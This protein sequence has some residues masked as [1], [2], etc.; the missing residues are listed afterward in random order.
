MNILDASCRVA[1]A[2]MTHDLG[3]FVQRADK[4]GNSRF[5]QDKLDGNTTLY[6]PFHEAGGYH[7]HRHAAY[8][9][10]AFDEL[11]SKWPDVIKGDMFPF[12][13]RTKT[14]TITDS[15]VN[16]AAAHHKPD[17][18]LQWIIAVADRTASGFEREEFEKYNQAEDK[19]DTGRNH[20]QARLLSVFEQLLLPTKQGSKDV[21][22]RYPLKALSPADIFPMRREE[23]EP[24]TDSAAQTEYSALW[25]AFVEGLDKI[26]QSHC[27][28]W[29]LWLDHFDSLWL[30]FTHAI[31][32]ATAFG[33]KPDVSLYDHSKATAALA[34]A[35]WRYG[36]IKNG[37]ETATVR[38]MHD[39]AGYDEKKFLLI[40]G[41]FFGVQNFIFAEGSQTNKQAAKILRGRSFQVALFTELAALR[42]LEAL[43]LPSTSQIT[44]AAGKFLIV[45]PNTPNTV[46]NMQK[47]RRE[48]DDWF[49]RHSYGLVGIIREWYERNPELKG[50]ETVLAIQPPRTR[51]YERNP[52]LKGIETLF[53]RRRNALQLGN[54]SQ[55]TA[56]RS[57]IFH[58]GQAGDFT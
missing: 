21:E 11:E 39:R 4:T 53:H 25:K 1:F 38:N 34:V 43:N 8:T 29:P 58:T 55:K 51:A 56:N 24:D 45:A 2:A 22:Y 26:P 18:Y 12:A 7:S 57:R 30:T 10:L 5:P 13:D 20:Y 31:P 46:E 17:T 3:K 40:Q 41:D 52:E 49:L 47:I 23:C 16:A 14:E 27:K 48:F 37:D 19:T 6:C 28:S 50:I 42:I 15:L 54:F 35:M 36:Q 32:S 33:I 9:A 44:N